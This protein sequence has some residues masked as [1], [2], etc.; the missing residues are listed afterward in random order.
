MDLITV[1]N[2]VY[3]VQ[4]VKKGL[5]IHA[6]ISV[7]GFSVIAESKEDA[8]AKLRHKVAIYEYN[9]NKGKEKLLFD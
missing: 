2:K 4:Y 7:E 3:S 1:N 6:A 5:K 9:K 8:L